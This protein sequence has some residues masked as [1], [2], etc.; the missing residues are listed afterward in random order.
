MYSAPFCIQSTKQLYNKF[1]S[2]AKKR[3]TQRLLST[4]MTIIWMMTSALDN[5]VILY[6]TVGLLFFIFL[7]Q[8]FW[9]YLTMNF[10]FLQFF[11]FQYE[12]MNSVWNWEVPVA[13]NF[14]ISK[15]YRFETLNLK[16]DRFKVIKL[17]ISRFRTIE[18]EKF[19]RYK[20]HW[21]FENASI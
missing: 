21:S 13:F 12:E 7:Y 19:C 4:M 17:I 3:R 5:N 2:C 14:K 8:F 9:K 6:F 10:N 16:F 18:K 11:L 1:K 15:F 20:T